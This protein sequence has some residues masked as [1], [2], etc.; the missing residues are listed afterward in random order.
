MESTENKTETLENQTPEAAGEPE[1]QHSGAG[2]THSHAP[3]MNEAC[4]R[5]ISV[6]VPTGVVASET[7]N[8]VNKYRKHAAIPGFRK[9]KVPESIIR[10]RFREEIRS[11]VLDAL[12]PR[13]FREKVQ[14]QGLAPVSQP[15]VSD[16]HFLEGEPL[17][18]KAEFEVLPHIELSGYENI[19][20]AKKDTAVSDEEVEAALRELQE[21]QASFEP[22]EDREIK[23]GDFA[24]VS[25][26][27]K[28]LGSKAVV[29]KKREIASAPGEPAA[30]ESGPQAA[31]EA[32]E[33]EPVEVNDVM[34]NV[35]GENTVK[36]FSENLRGARP[37]DEREFEVA[38]A[39]DFSDERLAGQVIH[40]NVKVQGIKKK[41]LPELNDDFAKQI[42]EFATFDELKTRI[43][44]R[45]EAQKKH[46]VEHQEK[47][48]I[49]DQLVQQNDFPVP[50]ALLERQIDT[51]L[52]RG[53][54]ALASQGMRTED[55]RRLNF[56]R[57]RE[58]QRDAA[59]REVKA[60]L[61]LDKVAERENIEVT[62]QDI[63]TEV[64]MLALQSQQPVDALRARLA[65]EG[66]LE[67]L[68][69][70]IRNE[71]ALDFLYN[72]SA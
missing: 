11:E 14:E 30:E 12:L 23:D 48:S 66:S 68:R 19:S 44:E 5:E 39:D 64:Q 2:H 41:S 71:K 72:R 69:D 17:R 58:A 37:G 3:L 59:L 32:A 60:S 36:E 54:R 70:R 65:R 49:V 25:F 6:E 42:G 20:T 33:V 45:M 43:R 52:E 4:R 40:Y 35:G 63:D 22:L 51:R 16:L 9:G 50:Q 53:L 29:E 27:G 1:N 13:Y 67:R 56:E 46:E 28:A 24:L 62:D 38:Y 10:N 31:G 18:F 55:M 57:L 15:R 34:V 47:E 21:R 7:E 26:T 61:L 8:T